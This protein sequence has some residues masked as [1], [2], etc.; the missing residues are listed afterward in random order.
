[1][2][3]VG[4]P[5]SIY[6]LARAS[7]QSSLSPHASNQSHGGVAD[8]MVIGSIARAMDVLDVLPEEEE[9]KELNINA[10][11][12]SSSAS[13]SSPPVPN[14]LS[15]GR[16]GSMDEDHATALLTRSDDRNPP[17]SH[18]L[19]P[20]AAI[21][22]Q[23]VHRPSLTTTTGSLPT[24]PAVVV[25]G[26]GRSPNPAAPRNNN[27]SSSS[28]T[29]PHSPPSSEFTLHLRK[30]YLPGRI[31]H[32]VPGRRPD[33]RRCFGLKKAR[34]PSIVYPASQDTFQEIVVNKSMFTD[35]LPER[36]QFDRLD[37]PIEFLEPRDEDRPDEENVLSPSPDP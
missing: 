22:P 21:N 34:C 19:S 3:E 31:Y 10:N 29:S 24:V 5:S 2:H 35:H 27:T 26:S 9:H 4:S 30:C 20:P 37:I 17:L 13:S 36:Y 18:N 32:V 8:E 1:M 23:S 11:I 28:S 14:P 15:M 25:T 6:S 7:S 12:R 16:H 33:G